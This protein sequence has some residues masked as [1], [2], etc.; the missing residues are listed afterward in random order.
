M[1]FYIF[2]SS[3]NSL[4]QISCVELINECVRVTC[5]RCCWQLLTKA[6][7]A[8]LGSSVTP[9]E[10]HEIKD[11]IFYRNINWQKLQNREVQPPFK[12]KVVSTPCCHLT[13]H[14]IA[15]FVAAIIVVLESHCFGLCYIDIH[16]ITDCL[17]QYFNTVGWVFWPVKNC[18]PY[19]LYCVGADVKP[20]SIDQS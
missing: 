8:R 18:R 16:F 11:H 6:P 13:V 17:L 9:G 2:K 4:H 15:L 3:V 12:P 10:E 1:Q 14:S 20:C 5:W 7:N 19:N